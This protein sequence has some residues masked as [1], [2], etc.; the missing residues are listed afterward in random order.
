MPMVCTQVL[1]ISPK[2][3]SP[4][5]AQ[6]LT[7]LPRNRPALFACGLPQ[8]CAFNQELGAMASARCCAPFCPA[9]TEEIVR[10]LLSP[11]L[12]HF[13]QNALLDRGTFHDAHVGVAGSRYVLRAGDRAVVLADKI[14]RMRDAPHFGRGRRI[15][16]DQG[17]VAGAAGRG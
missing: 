10:R 3:R 8:A 1:S 15:D 16:A 5:M 11:R 12:I 4:V 9:M 2:L 13:L 6:P 7:W 14:H 17:H